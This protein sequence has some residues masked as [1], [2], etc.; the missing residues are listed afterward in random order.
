MVVQTHSFITCLGGWSQTIPQ[1]KKPDEG[2]LGWHGSMWSVVVRPVE[3]T[4]KFSKMMRRLM[5]EKLTLHSLATALVYI[6]AV[7]IPNVLSL[8]T[9]HFFR[10]AFYCPQHKVHLCNNPAV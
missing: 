7:S 8:K 9:A 6:P 1:V 4:A 10:V 3:R 2:V 5:V